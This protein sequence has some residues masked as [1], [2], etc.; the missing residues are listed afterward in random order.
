LNGK[1]ATRGARYRIGRRDMVNPSD[2]V[3]WIQM[4]ADSPVEVTLVPKG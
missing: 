2:L 4:E 3:I 1:P